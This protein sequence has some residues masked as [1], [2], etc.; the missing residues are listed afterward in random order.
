MSKKSKTKSSKTAFGSDYTDYFKFD[1]GSN[2]N[3][4]EA[5]GLNGDDS[6]YVGGRNPFNLSLF[7]GNG[8]DS[9][10]SDS[11]VSDFNTTKGAFQRS[12]VRI[13]GEGG[14]DN[15]IDSFGGSYIL[16]G[17]D[18]DDTI[19]YHTNTGIY[20]GFTKPKLIIDG[21]QGNDRISYFNFPNAKGVIRGG[22][23]DDLIGIAGKSGGGGINYFGDGGDDVFYLKM[24]TNERDTIINGG[25]G[26]DELYISNDLYKRLIRFEE[27][28]GTTR[29]IFNY[30][31]KDG[32]AYESSITLI[33]I[34]HIGT[35][36][37]FIPYK[38]G[39]YVN[40]SGGEIQSLYGSNQPYSPGPNSGMGVVSQYWDN[41]SGFN[42]I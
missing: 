3:I 36:R 32:I 7:G 21:G 20:Y 34:E 25:A 31:Q 11:N 19:K 15:I 12:A 10:Q 28:S 4:N 16:S 29:M 26:Y 30:W 38:W 35:A 8:N 6:F 5:F 27:S 42:L 23:G 18:G 22:E 14:N 13:Y 40:E 37:D 9:F 17:G 33:D 41:N 2:K 1:R 24:M 39:S